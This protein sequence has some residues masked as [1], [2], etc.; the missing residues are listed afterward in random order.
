MGDKKGIN[1]KFHNNEIF[2]ELA[3]SSQ[4]VPTDEFL[5]GYEFEFFTK[6]SKDETAAGLTKALAKKVTVP[7]ETVGFGDKKKK[8]YT[9][10]SG[11]HIS[12]DEFIL[13]PD[14]SGGPNMRELITGPLG[15]SE[16]R[17]ILI[18]VLQ[19]IQRNGWTTDRAGVHI[20]ISL[21]PMSKQRRQ[22]D[23]SNMNILKMCLSFDE[24]TIYN[25]FPGRRG[26]T[27]ARSVKEIR[28]ANKFM[29]RETSGALL[30]KNNYIWPTTKY[31]GINFLKVENN[32]L[33][34]R[35][36]GGADYEKKTQKILD[37]QDIFCK[38]IKH[39]VEYPEFTESDTFK[40]KKLLESHKKIAT[41]FSNVEKFI[42]N[43][44]DF[45]VMVNLQSH[46]GITKTFW[47]VLREGL[48]DLIVNAGV[49]K[50]YFN[51][52]S[53]TALFQIKDATLKSCNNISK[54]EMVNC[55][56]DGLLD[57][58]SFLH[59]EIKNSHIEDSEIVGGNL[60]MDSKVKSTPI[61]FSNRLE[62]CYVE[63]EKDVIN[64]ELEDCIIRKG[65]I[66][67]LAVI[68]NCIKV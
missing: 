25:K 40:L 24:N 4:V 2:T 10:H 61:Q 30:N 56:I 29:F 35:Y 68:K 63:N 12:G 34:F 52:D 51:Y 67:E 17:I 53:D 38:S 13:E 32:Y 37:C 19:W 45:V 20:N 3:P 14:Y 5:I 41:S 54:F 59:C 46:I 7:F 64:G 55:K 57:N 62:G 27:Y 9:V 44:P 48:Y 50:G 23:I 39:V 11:A 6:L 58:C 15:E 33:E 1:P 43:Y 16:A 21:S 31:Y 18:K 42:Y 28:P 65:T 8:S 60:V 66:G 49:E 47:S 26:N 36:L 22:S